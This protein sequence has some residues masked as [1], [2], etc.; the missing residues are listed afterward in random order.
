MNL[1][2]ICVNFC[3]IPAV[4]SVEA[5][6][7]GNRIGRALFK[8]LASN[9]FLFAAWLLGALESTYGQAMLA[10]LVFSWFGDVFLLSRSERFF[11]AG[12]VSF[13]LAHIAYGAAFVLHGID[14]RAALVA[15]ALLILIAIPLLRW[16]LPNVPAAMRFPVIAYM[17]TIS[18]MVT[19]AAGTW[20]HAG[21]LV[22]IPGAAVFFVSDIFVAR[23]R[24][25][26]PGFVNSQVGL[27]LYYGGQLL[28]AYSV[29]F[30]G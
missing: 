5:E 30:G 7:R 25:I 18:C 15:L 6:R 24:F 16:I 11:Q 23:D 19:L 14:P 29:S 22:I 27:P 12:L 13:L 10:G 20:G 8:I 26:A 2:L 1:F 28:L 4:L 17:I 21:Y 3:L 9:G